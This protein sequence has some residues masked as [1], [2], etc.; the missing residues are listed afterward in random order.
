MERHSRTHLKMLERFKI[1]NFGRRKADRLHASAQSL[2]DRGRDDEAIAKYKEAVALNPEKSESYYNIGLIYK[3]RGAWRDSFEFNR[4]AHDL[5]PSSEAAGWNL[6]IA[7]TAL[8]DWNTAR[9]VWSALGIKLD[10][11]RGPIV[12]DFGATPVRLNPDGNAEVV[13]ARRIDPVRARIISIPTGESEFCFDDTVLHDGAAVGYRML[14]ESE[15]PVFN[16]LELFEASEFSTFRAVVRVNEKS[17]IDELE[18]RLQGLGMESE[19][20][21]ANFR[22]LCKACSEGRPHDHK[23]EHRETAWTPE[24]RVGIAARA[25]DDVEKA[26]NEWAGAGA[27]DVVDLRCELAAGQRIR[28]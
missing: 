12:C 3:Y 23:T 13:W 18:K 1:L 15:R 20:W 28:A 7:A 27:R 6:A 11:G 22:L 5:D 9:S 8:R 4:K 24:R 14:G 10:Q 21:T 25:L 2:S 26:L 19:D 17:D 16:V